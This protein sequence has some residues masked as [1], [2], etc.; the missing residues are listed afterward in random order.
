MNLEGFDWE[1]QDQQL[2]A[3][4]IDATGRSTVITPNIGRS[5]IRGGEAEA[6]VLLTPKTILSADLQYLDTS[7]KSFTYQTLVS[8]GLPYTGCAVT[9]DATTPS[10]YDVNCAGKPIFNAPH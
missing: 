8:A 6:Q 9:V 4:G 7:Y 3:L 10:R 1:Y 2:S 5:Y